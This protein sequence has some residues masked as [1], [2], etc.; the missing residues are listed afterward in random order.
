MEI[1]LKINF[2]KNFNFFSMETFVDLF[3]PEALCQKL[4]FSSR[5]FV[6]KTGAREWGVRGVCVECVRVCETV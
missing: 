2:Y 4:R 6:S 1:T 3:L 5:F